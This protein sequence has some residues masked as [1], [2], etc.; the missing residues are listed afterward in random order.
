MNNF[1]QINKSEILDDIFG[2]TFV[3]ILVVQRD[4]VINL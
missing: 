4:R 2:N 1:S 3:A